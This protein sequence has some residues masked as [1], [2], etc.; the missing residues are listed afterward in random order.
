MQTSDLPY[1]LVGLSLLALVTCFSI[2][3]SLRLRSNSRA[4][5][6]MLHDRVTSIAKA[7]DMQLEQPSEPSGWPSMR[8]L[9]RA[10]VVRLQPRS[11]D[12]RS[13]LTLSFS[14]AV[15]PG[16]GRRWI[17][18]SDRPEPAHADVL[19]S[20][21]AYLARQRDRWLAACPSQ[22]QLIQDL[23]S[24]QRRPFRIVGAHLVSHSI[25]VEVEN[26]SAAADDS[27][28]IASDKTRELRRVIDDLIS[29]AEAFPSSS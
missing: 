12:V 11:L 20:E 16:A 14:I 23:F 24:P 25:S 18:P 10:H 27:L 3:Q 4:T 17:L 22:R 1:L 5:S 19:A 15:A 28:A 6:L 7:L 26:S 9:V 21:R 13:P 2:W 29:I 8:G